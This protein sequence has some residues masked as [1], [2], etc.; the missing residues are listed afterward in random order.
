MARAKLHAKPYGIA[1]RFIQT[2]ASKNG[3]SFQTQERMDT[4][5]GKNQL[6]CVKVLEECHGFILEDWGH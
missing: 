6:T 3:K 2:L 5:V 1:S 4:L